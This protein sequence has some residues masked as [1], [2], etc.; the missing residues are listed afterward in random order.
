MSTNVNDN[1]D[2]V[3]RTS[4]ISNLFHKTRPSKYRV[5]P[6]KPGVIKR[7]ARKLHYE[8][9]KKS[10]RKVSKAIENRIVR[11]A[12][13][14]RV[15]DH[16]IRDIPLLRSS[17][18]HTHPNCAGERT[19]VTLFMQ[20]LA[21]QCAYDP[22]TVSMSSPDQLNAEEGSRYFFWAKD[23]A[24]EMRDDPIKA[25]SLL[26][27][28]DVDFHVDMNK[29]L[30][31]FKPMLIYTIVPTSAG[32]R[33][34]EF[35]YFFK[36]NKIH[37]KVSGGSDYCHQIWDYK[38]DVV[39]VV[40]KNK[41]LLCYHITQHA[42]KSSP[43]RRV[44]SILPFAS[45]PY[46]YYENIPQQPL[47][48][49]TYNSNGVSFIDST[50]DDSIS[51]ALEGSIESVRIRRKMLEAIKIRMG[52]SNVLEKPGDVE[53]MLY[54][55][56]GDKADVAIDSCLLFEIL[57]RQAVMT[58]N[59]VA[60]TS[61]ATHYQPVGPLVHEE[62]KD[63]SQLITSPLVTKPALF[64][65]QTYN[66]EVA[67]ISGRVDKPRNDVKMPLA[68][69]NYGR[70]FAKLMIPDN[71]IHQGRPITIAEVKHLQNKPMQRA[72]TREIEHLIGVE[73]RNKLRSFIKNEAYSA[74]NDPRVITT[75]AA[76]LTLRM[77]A[78]T[79]A[80]KEDFLKKCPFY[81]PGKAPREIHDRMREFGEEGFVI[82]DY[83]RFDGSISRALQ[84]LVNKIY[85]RW[86]NDGSDADEWAAMFRQVF[87]Q[88]AFTKKGYAYDPGYGTRS[89]SPITTDGNTMI[90]AFISYCALRDMGFP[91]EEAWSK[92]GLYTGDD[93]L[94]R[95]IPGMAAA[96][97][98]AVAAMGLNIDIAQTLPDESITFAGRTFPRPMTSYTS[99]QDIK[100]T[101]PKLHV[102]SNKSVTPE[103]AAYNRAAGYYVTDARTPL[104]GTWARKVLVNCKKIKLVED[105]AE[106][107][108]A[109]LA[110][111]MTSEERFKIA[112]G[113]WPQ[114]NPEL[115]R[116]SVADIL[117]I[118]NNE[119]NQLEL[120]IQ[121]A[122]DLHKL[123]VVWDN[124]DEFKPKLTSLVNGELLRPHVKSE[125]CK[126]ESKP[127]N[128]S[129]TPQPQ[130]GS[131]PKAA[132]TSSGKST[133]S[134]PKP[135]PSNKKAQASSQA[136]TKTK[137]TASPNSSG[138][139]SSTSKSR[140]PN[141][142]DNATSA[143]NAKPNVAEPSP[144]PK[145]KKTQLQEV[146][147]LLKKLNPS[148]TDHQV[149]TL[150]E[151]NNPRQ[152]RY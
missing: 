148:L 115:I 141:R 82:T 30:K 118:T 28:T 6:Q 127:T 79:Y 84:Q 72:R 114:D 71:K 103:I 104:V 146:T 124:T 130:T 2:D 8:F 20:E 24:Q 100:R 5:T 85:L 17:I 134:A 11:S 29:Y 47:V 92:L 12:D 95:N 88:R 138:P 53:F 56:S 91:V 67:A 105:N 25:N 98:A 61:I 4:K 73:P 147:E 35:E 51:L 117:N 70:E 39:T 113:S 23:F 119:L 7:F 58:N 110:N 50:L 26:I 37:Y 69:Q 126:T 16:K 65:A 75:N 41:N 55:T 57:K 125:P 151:N 140:A 66:A 89:G 128:N 81:G 49:K 108:E 93:G 48:R 137:L 33:E 132:K 64:P 101:L 136:Q 62:V 10:V 54:K 21:K 18:G 83:N 22:Y 44:I 142:N 107:L 111:S 3:P 97:T 68:Y 152:E 131:I 45:V 31:M 149:K 40:D 143:P 76:A 32:H 144:P 59:V 86:L 145:R 96:M 77:S 36:D 74:P 42:L 60:T 87:I 19:A 38:G 43:H 80:A 94:N 120:Q 52:T 122:E 112:N 99:H 15:I 150:I 34:E 139:A 106:N 63:P 14:R 9:I 135:K 123:P 13:L 133:K 121:A 46:P 27:F 129:S 78:F 90:N 1:Q 109:L 102:S 116:Q